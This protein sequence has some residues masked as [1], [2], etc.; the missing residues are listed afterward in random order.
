MGG[1]AEDEKV[2]GQGGNE[3]VSDDE[4]VQRYDE[5][6]RMQKRR[7]AERGKQEKSQQSKKQQ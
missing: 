1:E 2:I 6:E 3:K 4:E 5:R 7:K